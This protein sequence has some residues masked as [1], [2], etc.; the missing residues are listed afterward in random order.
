MSP[1]STYFLISEPVKIDAVVPGMAEYTVENHPDAHFFRLG[2]EVPKILLRAKARVDG[3]IIRRV[4]LMVGGGGENW[5]EIAPT[6][7]A[8][9]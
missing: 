6:P 3:Q 7:R 1:F 5:I 2:A 8:L 4:I 9:R